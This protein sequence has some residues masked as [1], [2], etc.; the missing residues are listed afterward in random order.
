M[1]WSDDGTKDG[2]KVFSRV[3]GCSGVGEEQE[4]LDQ[5]GCGCCFGFGMMV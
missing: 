2:A 3:W 1:A 5:V 4:E